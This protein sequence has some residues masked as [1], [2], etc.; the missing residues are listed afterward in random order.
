MTRHVYDT[1]SARTF[2]GLP[3]E[4]STFE[5]SRV[6]VL[7]VPYDGTTSYRPGARFGP[8]A[9]IAA[10]RFVETYDEELGISPAC[11]G[12]H[13]LPE[14]PPAGTGADEMTERIWRAAREVLGKAGDRFLLTL[15]GEHSVTPGVVRAFAERYPDLSVLHLDAHADM[16]A[17]YEGTRNSHACACARMRDHVKTTVSVGIR[18]LSGEEA[19]AIR[20]DEVPVFWAREI[21]GRT[22]WI[23]KA[24]AG[25]GSTVYVTVDLD[26]FDPAIMPATGTPEPGGLSWYEVCALLR[27]TARRREIVGADVVELAPA[28]GLHAPEFLA[29]RLAVKL[30][31][32]AREAEIR[33]LDGGPAL[34]E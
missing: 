25:L 2:L 20:R 4:S 6:L 21:A 26:V 8:E 7:P 27:E 30:V 29:A 5:E 1:G 24:I 32:Y 11:L 22:D 33:D 17:E 15:G 16:R 12:F 14:V 31:T 19:A 3:E 9:I 13:L 10:S 18:S 34:D 23:E 28:A